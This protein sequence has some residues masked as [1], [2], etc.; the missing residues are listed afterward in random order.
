VYV[1]CHLLV[2][3][4]LGLAFS[5]WKRD[6][7]LVAACV[8]G[9]ILPDLVDKPLGLLISGTVA[10][11]RIYAHTLLFALIL[12]MA[13]AVLWRWSSRRTG[14]LVIAVALGVLSH[15]VLDAMWLEPAAWCWPLLG[16]FP[17]PKMDIP[18]LPYLLGDLLQPAEWLFAAASL[19]LAASLAGMRGSRARLAPALSLVMAFFAMWVFFCAVTGSP[20][21]ITGWEDRG[22]NA[23]V[24][25]VLLAGAVG[26][27]RVGAL[28]GG[29]EK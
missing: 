15:Q 13:G 17:P 16:P 22:D 25:L 9:A 20:C 26:V 2:G 3:L 28:S 14:I 24:A 27:D 5:T 19:F 6:R 29:R 4:L 18:I 12:L 1:F 7:L 8:L 10:Y 21:A 11:G 23:I